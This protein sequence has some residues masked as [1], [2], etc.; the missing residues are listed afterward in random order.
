MLTKGVPGSVPAG[1]LTMVLLA[2]SIPRNFPNHGSPANNE[3]SKMKNIDFL[4]A[5]LLLAAM[6]LHITGLE[7]AANSYTWS[8]AMVLA[9]L[10]AGAGLWFVFVVSQWYTSKE[11]VPRQPMF[12]MRF[13][14]NRVFMGLLA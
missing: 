2:I 14:K 7:Q 11:T 12:P 8:S 9:P 6:T 13:F 10:L 1:V 5:A 3:P 4:G